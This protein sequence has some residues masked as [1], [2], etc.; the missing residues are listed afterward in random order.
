MILPRYEDAFASLTP[1]ELARLLPAMGLPLV[2]PSQRP[3][4]GRD[5]LEHA[6]Q[7]HISHA[8]VIMSLSQDT[9]PEAVAAVERLIMRPI[10][11]RTPYEVNVSRLARPPGSHRQS[12]G[13]TPGARPG[14]I[15]D[16]HVIRLLTASNPKKPGSES[17]VRFA[18]YS[19]GM[20]VGQYLA[21][22][23]RRPDLVWDTDKG[24]I[25]TE[26]PTVTPI[27]DQ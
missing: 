18:Y 11:R 4:T 14:A 16:S 1:Q 9:T 26:E 2:H 13:T 17:H 8:D 27:G 24:F 3:F 20:T 5:L 15:P 12:S 25:R 19:D 22:G 7:C 21:L 10:D 6:R 23:G